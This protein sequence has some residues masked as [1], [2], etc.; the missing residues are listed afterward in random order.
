MG[1][2]VHEMTR[3]VL[4]EEEREDTDM[5]DTAGRASERAGERGRDFLECIYRYHVKL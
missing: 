5:A 1:V 3:V 4:G 2:L